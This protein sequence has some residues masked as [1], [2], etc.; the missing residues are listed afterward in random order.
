MS[1]SAF[2]TG[3][4]TVSNTIT[5]QTLI[6]QTVSS[7]VVFSSGSN[8]FGNSLANTH[9][10]TGSVTITGSLSVNNS[11]VILSNQTGSMSVQNAQTAS[12][13]ANPFDIGIAEFNSTSS[14]TTAGTTAVSSIPTGSFN[15]AFYNY[16]IASAS[17]ARAGQIM[18]VWSG[19]IVRY[20]EVTTTDIGNTATASF[21]VAISGQNV[22]LNFTA[23]GVWTVKS[24]ANLL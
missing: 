11:S 4:L 10:F 20:T 17:N 13:G 21:A 18:S 15:S 3:S 16:Y 12:V 2:I 23:P 9:Q 5:A 24:I 14:T 22:R 6:V 8:I 1:G 19:S 7:S